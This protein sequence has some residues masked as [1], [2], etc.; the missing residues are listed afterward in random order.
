MYVKTTAK[1]ATLAG[2]KHV[3]KIRGTKNLEVEIN[4]TIDTVLFHVVD[5]RPAANGCNM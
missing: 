4:G 5:G 3:L 2:C 1:H